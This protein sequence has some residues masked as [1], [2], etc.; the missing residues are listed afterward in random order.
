MIG[1]VVELA[2]LVV[3]L[4][5]A[6]DCDY[7]PCSSDQTG[8]VMIL[9]SCVAPFLAGQLAA[10]SSSIVLLSR[11]NIPFV[12]IGLIGHAVGVIGGAALWLLAFTR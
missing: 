2:I 9:L 1:L 8:L 3:V 5:S 4:A 10:G 6:A 7:E 12:I 11:R